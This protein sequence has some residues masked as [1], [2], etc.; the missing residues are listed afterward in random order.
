MDDGHPA[1]FGA[2]LCARGSPRR[3]RSPPARDGSAVARVRQRPRLASA[4]PQDRRHRARRQPAPA[5]AVLARRLSR[6]VRLRAD[7]RVRRQGKR[8][9][10]P[11][12]H[13]PG[14]EL[15]RRRNRSRGPD[16][17]DLRA[18]ALSGR[19]RPRD[20]R[21]W[22]DRCAGRRRRRGPERREARGH[23]PDDAH[24]RRH[25][26]RAAP[27]PG[28]VRGSAGAGRDDEAGPGG[29]DDRG[30]AR[31]REHRP[32]LPTESGRSS[33][34]GDRRTSAGSSRSTRSP[35]RSARAT[36]SCPSSR[37]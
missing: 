33:S 24:G 7:S 16:V 31:P 3:R 37:R 13:D 27:A 18:G 23:G 36:R 1:W 14:H 26:R 9:R 35:A 32:L 12:G 2:D 8:A 25:D 29:S 28:V 15:P 30:V 17:H 4:A 21:R 22:R 5:R 19:V 11:R 6:H 34:T 20:A 10:G